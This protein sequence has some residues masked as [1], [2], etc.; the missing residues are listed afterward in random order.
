M[1]GTSGILISISFFSGS[2]L[3]TLGIIG[4]YVGKI[5][6]QTKGRDRYIIKDIKSNIK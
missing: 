3:L 5:F 2:I 6:E 1:S 4:V